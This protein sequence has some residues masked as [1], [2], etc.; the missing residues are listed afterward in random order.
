MSEEEKK[1]QCTPLCRT[2]VSDMLQF[3]ASLLPNQ[4][5][6][7]IHTLPIMHQHYHQNTAS[8]TLVNIGY[9]MPP[10]P[11][12]DMMSQPIYQPHCVDVAQMPLPVFQ[13]RAILSMVTGSPIQHATTMP[14]CMVPAMPPQSAAPIHLSSVGV[15]MPTIYTSHCN[16]TNCDVYSTVPSGGNSVKPGSVEKETSDAQS[17]SSDESRSH[18]LSSDPD[19]LLNQSTSSQKLTPRKC[20][21]AAKFNVPIKAEE[22]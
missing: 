14:S 2:P 17:S 19:Q 8:P 20:R 12:L 22:G 3:A 9:G 13:D 6:G 18:D 5:P 7:V 11:T 21:I 4:Q 16:G 1:A 10:Q 15:V